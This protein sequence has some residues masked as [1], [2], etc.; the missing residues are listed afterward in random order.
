MSLC[1]C[2]GSVR[3]AEP[4]GPSRNKK[5]PDMLDRRGNEA[6]PLV[7]GAIA[8]LYGT[9]LVGFFFS[10]NGNARNTNN[11]KVFPFFVGAFELVCLLLSSILWLTCLVCLLIL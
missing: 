8:V 2:D 6:G 4:H 7:L 3:V 11:D 5:G 10:S 1:W 9:I